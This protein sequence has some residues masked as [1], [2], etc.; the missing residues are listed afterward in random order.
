MHINR[1]LLESSDITKH[2]MTGRERQVKKQLCQLLIDRGHR[3]YAERFWKLDFNIIDSSKHPD[4]TAA[5]SFD[6]A[7]V[8]IS[9]GFLGNGQGI[10]NQLD[11]LLRHEMAHNLMMHQIRLMYI[12][13][14]L[15]A[16]DPE[17]AYT[18]ISYSSSL[19]DLLNIIEDFEI[20]NRRYSSADKQIVR[21]MM[22]N[23]RV[24]GGLVTEDQRGWD[25][26]SLEQMYEELSKELIRINSEIRS[27]PSWQPSSRTANGR[28][29]VDSIEYSTARAISVYTNV[30]KPSGIKAPIDV[31]MK[32]KIYKN[33]PEVFQNLVKKLYEAFKDF[34]SD[35]DKQL[36]LD[37]VSDIAVTSPQETFDVV[38]PK[39]GKVICTLYTPENKLIAADILK[40][41]AGHINYDPLKFNVKRKKNTQEYKDA[42]NNVIG[43]LDSS[44]FDDETLQQIRNAIEAMQ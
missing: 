31:F 22:L 23:G 40:N 14:K 4:F 34:S 1:A 41:I 29:S 9:D 33:W 39:T 30:M 13:K 35:A 36:L 37:I 8:F 25:K 15:H 26:M 18:F 10:F 28:T 5:I 7:T 20:S 44:K 6:E 19:H 21:N 24:I 42:W 43:K 38:S 2:F 17:E 11:V 16:N 27:D 12:F 3:K 32:S